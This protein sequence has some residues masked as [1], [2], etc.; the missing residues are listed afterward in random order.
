MISR[1][2][3]ALLTVTCA[4][5]CQTNSPPAPDASEQQGVLSD[6]AEYAISDEANLPN[7]EF[8]QTTRRFENINN[9][10]W[11]PIDMIVER[12]MYLD[13]H[14]SSKFASVMRSIFLP[15]TETEFAWQGW[16][17][18]RGKRMHVYGYRVLELKSS[19]HL[20]TKEH[21]L[22]LVTG[23]HGLVF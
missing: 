8:T 4:L 12:L 7:F 9:S 18:L 5:Q 11:R 19:F 16:F 21:S 20:E 3:A 14:E 13:H 1:F 23:Y 6:A 17:T 2:A 10:G 15:Q 22:D